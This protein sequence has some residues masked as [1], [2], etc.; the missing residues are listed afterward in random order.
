M[1][2][3]PGATTHVVAQAIGGCAGAN[4]P[5]ERS[6]PPVARSTTG[7]Q[8]ASPQTASPQPASPRLS[9][10]EAWRD[11]FRGRALAQGISPRVFDAAFAG[12]VRSSHSRPRWTNRQS[13]KRAF[14]RP[15]RARN[16]VM[17]GWPVCAVMPPST[18]SVV[19]VM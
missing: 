17:L 8:T 10:F 14:Q 9:S 6:A 15:P 3:I 12:V 4:P 5:L 18:T 11:G 19:P 16:S 1:H 2:T 7:P 13:A